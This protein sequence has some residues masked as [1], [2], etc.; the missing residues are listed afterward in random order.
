MGLDPAV[1]KSN[2]GFMKPAALFAFFLL[3]FFPAVAGP[4]SLKVTFE[5]EKDRDKDKMTDQKLGEGDK[6]VTHYDF[7]FKVENLS[8]EEFSGVEARVYVVVSPFNFR[9]ENEVQVYKVLEKKD[10]VIGKQ[11]TT[12]VDVGSVDLT[13]TDSMKGATM[14]H[15]GWKYQGYLAELSLGGQVFYTDN[16]G[17]GDTKKAVAAYLKN[18]SPKRK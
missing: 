11:G 8:S 17:G 2:H 5:A 4:E 3:P 13:I 9:N 12:K 10:V 16:A 15:S 6:I 14:W 18:P 7:G 1:G